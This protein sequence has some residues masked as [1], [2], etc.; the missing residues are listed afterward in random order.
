MFRIRRIYDDVLPVNQTAIAEV[1]QIFRQQ[2]PAASTKDIDALPDK[3]RNPFHSQFR[4]ILLIAENARGHIAGFA[5]MMHDPGLAFCYL[6]W[7]ASR[8]SIRGR[9]IGA[10]LYEYVRDEALSM[11]AQ[12]LLFECLPDEPDRCRDPNTCKQNA[13]RLKFYERYGARPIIN[14]KYET[15]VPGGS[16]DNLPFL[17]F[18]DLDTDRLLRREHARRIVRAILERKY[19]SLCPPDYIQLVVN[20]FRDDPIRL[21]G[22][23]YAKSEPDHKPAAPKPP[24]SIAWTINDKHQIHHIRERGYVESP[25]RISAITAELEPTGLFEKLPVKEYPLKHILAVHDAKFVEYLERACANA[26]DNKSVY[27]YVFPI[28]NATRPPRE[29]SVLAGYYCIDTF[30]PIHRRLHPHRR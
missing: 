1:G 30:T 2:F 11:G 10:A 27:P 5:I 21:R 29:M 7:L 22:F 26:P 17:V 3:L 16:D 9:G 24:P 20:S 6:D 14:T 18:D 13:A 28:R 25:V 8:S 12:G 15:P 4:T 19:A 23:R